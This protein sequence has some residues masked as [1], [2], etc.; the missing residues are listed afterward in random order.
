MA[1]VTI[2]EGGAIPHKQVTALLVA[3]GRGALVARLDGQLAD[4]L[5]NS[6]YVVSAWDGATLVGAARVVSDRVAVTILQHVGVHPDYQH[7]G[8]G[9]ELLGRCLARSGHA[10][11][12]RPDRQAVLGFACRERAADRGSSRRAGHGDGGY[13]ARAS[14]LPVPRHAGPGRPG[15]ARTRT[16]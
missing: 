10:T 8:L 15:P 5:H 13:R 2:R 3:P 16:G 14:A 12:I 11:I 7:H 6:T 4:V 9:G 1:G